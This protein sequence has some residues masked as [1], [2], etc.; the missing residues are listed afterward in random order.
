MA[1]GS[2]TELQN[3]LMLARDVDYL[4]LNVYKLLREQS[5]STHKLVNGMIRYLNFKPTNTNY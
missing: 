2:L 1:L 3:H 5:E 4:S